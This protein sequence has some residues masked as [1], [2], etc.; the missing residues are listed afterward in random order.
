VD[1]AV[2]ARVRALDVRGVCVREEFTR[3]TAKDLSVGQWL[4]I[5]GA[6]GRGL[7]GL[8]RVLDRRLRGTPGLAVLAKDGRGKKIAHSADPAVPPRDGGIVRLTIDTRVQ[9]ILDEEI[10]AVHA[11]FTPV[12]VSGIVMEPDTGRILALDSVPGLEPSDLGRLS[13]AELRPRL[14]NHPVQ[15]VYEYGSTFK[16]FVV[17]AALDLGLVTPDTRVQCENGCWVYR[18]RRLHDHHPYGLL[19]VTDLIVHSSNIGAAKV[20]LLLGDERLRQFVAWFHFGSPLGISLPAEE[21]GLVTP[22]RRWTY[23]TTTS[24]PMGQEIAGTPLQLITAF[25]ALI[26]GGRLMQPYIVES[27]EDPNTGDHTCRTPRRLHQVLQPRTSAVM[28]GILGQV[29]ER[30]TGRALRRCK[31]P[32]GGKTGTAQKGNPADGK[33]VASFVGFAPVD[34]PRVCVLVMADEPQGAH[35]GGQVAAP[36]VGRIID[37]TLSLLD[38]APQD[39]RRG[40]AVAIAPAP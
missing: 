6:D 14:R 2:A 10:H 23:Y 33:Y 28:R 3:E 19:T 13:R 37:R 39:D 21:P 8:E 20:G 5:V 29:V 38:S 34:R 31:Y 27:F 1:E 16:P 30:G 25:C 22:T 35:Y 26:N 4:G 12:A 32:I 9:Q 7:E 11:E 18:R 40:P 17:A 24:V 36:A 15:S